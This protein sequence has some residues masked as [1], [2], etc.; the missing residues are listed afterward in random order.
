MRSASGGLGG[1]IHHARGASA[2]DNWVYGKLIG[3]TPCIPRCHYAVDSSSVGVVVHAGKG[4]RGAG[5]RGGV[6]Y[7]RHVLVPID[8]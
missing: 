2:N 4:V 5:G 1:G 3:T 8:R 6:I 7:D